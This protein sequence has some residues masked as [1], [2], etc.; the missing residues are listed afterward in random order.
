MAL[1]RAAIPAYLDE[2]L[3]SASKQRAWAS[4]V[5]YEMIDDADEEPARLRPPARAAQSGASPTRRLQSIPGGRETVTYRPARAVAPPAQEQP[6]RAYDRP[7]AAG[8]A[9]AL[10][11]GLYGVGAALAVVALY[12]VVSTLVTWTQIKLDDMAY[13]NPR[14]THLDAVVGAGDSEAQPTH[15]IAMNLNRQVSVIELPGGDLSKAV[16]INGPYLF[17]DGENLT[18]IKMRVEDING[19]GKPDLLL[20]VKNEELAYINDK[21]NFRPITADEK[22]KVEQAMAAAAGATK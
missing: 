3:P 4:N 10:R 8:A 6:T 12:L 22:V 21:A 16:A 2:D 20:T 7:E 1:P 18:P 5:P 14:T 9:S 15:F 17:G 11:M 19:D 13:G